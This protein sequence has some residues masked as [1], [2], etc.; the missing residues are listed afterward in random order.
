VAGSK[1]KVGT[2]LGCNHCH[3]FL[4]FFRPSVC[5]TMPVIS[6]LHGGACP[7]SLN[8]LLPH[9]ACSANLGRCSIR[10]GWGPPG[11]LWAYPKC[12]ASIRCWEDHCV[13]C[14]QN[15]ESKVS[16]RA[17]TQVGVDC[18]RV[19]LK[20]ISGGVDCLIIWLTLNCWKY[21]VRE[22]CNDVL[23]GGELNLDVLGGPE[24]LCALLIQK[25]F[26]TGVPKKRKCC[27]RAIALGINVLVMTNE[28][29]L[30]SCY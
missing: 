19:C 7:V 10:V 16:H 30:G 18:P 14:I 20:E 24:C 2:G 4:Q 27:L 26:W 28:L 3:S 15:D 23:E 22:A 25:C 8:V 5:P 12:W 6:L 13:G 21:R 11:G 17:S 9:M 1:W 29:Y